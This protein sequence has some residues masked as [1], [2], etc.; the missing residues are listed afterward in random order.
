MTSIQERLLHRWA[1]QANLLIWEGV[2]NTHD[3]AFMECFKM[4]E[5][6]KRRWGVEGERG[7]KGRIT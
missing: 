6:Q 5:Y 1:G 2:T 4:D 3:H 7:L